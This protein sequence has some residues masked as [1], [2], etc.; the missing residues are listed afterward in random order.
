MARIHFYH[1][2]DQLMRYSRQHPALP[3]PFAGIAMYADMSQ[4]TMTGDT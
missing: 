4:A 2:K 1:V 3:D